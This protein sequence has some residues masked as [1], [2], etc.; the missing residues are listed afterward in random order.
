MDIDLIKSQLEKLRRDS[1]PSE[2]SATESETI[3]DFFGWS[4]R[5]KME[6]PIDEAEL[7]E[8]E[9]RYGINLPKDYRAFLTELGNGGAGPYY[10]IYPLAELEE[11]QVPLEVLN[12]LKK[13]FRLSGPWNGGRDVPQ[14]AN[15]R[16]SPDA[17]YYGDDI[18]QGALPIATQ[19]C[20]LDYWMVVTGDNPGEIWLDSRTDGEGIAPVTTAQGLRLTFGPWYMLWLC[21]AVEKW[22]QR[23]Q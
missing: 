15:D 4:H 5:Y 6:A 2:W 17:S 12:A 21:E 10:G 13:P 11:D 19:G 7:A 18:M 14:P 3:G 23:E 20:A 9:S 8:F 1:W 16:Y 22:G